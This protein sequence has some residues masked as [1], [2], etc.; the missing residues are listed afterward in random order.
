MKNI[1][2][3]DDNINELILQKSFDK[4]TAEEREKAI[5]YVGG[6]EEYNSLRNTLL[7]ITTSFSI[8]EE[9]VFDTDLKSDLLKQ[10]EQ[11]FGANNS[12][13]KIVPFYQKPFFQLA[14][15]ASVALMIFF[16]FPFFNNSTEKQGQ[17]AMNENTKESTA[18]PGT[19]N[20]KVIPDLSVSHD[21]NIPAAEKSESSKTDNSTLKNGLGQ[22]IAKEEEPAKIP[23]MTNP[24]N[25][26][27]AGDEII[28]SDDSKAESKDLALDNKPKPIV[29]ES[30]FLY[31]RVN[32][33]RKEKES[34]KSKKKA[35]DESMREEEVANNTVTKVD[36][37]K[38]LESAAGTSV[39]Q[40]NAPS[41]NKVMAA[42]TV[43][44]FVEENK[45][46]MLD[47]LFTTF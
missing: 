27:K 8:E 4:L 39:N 37:D 2:E 7:A 23:G 41:P 10:F 9:V 12:R 43:S 45:T 30:E 29:N 35:N 33:E 34:K 13:V 6:E 14:V 28:L 16:A 21:T 5:A 22:E 20:D 11:K 17:L 36:A 18:I 40:Y 32:R 44:A 42:T 15:A 31:E 47:L 46:E 3:I 25:T 38:M 1:N 19:V 24:V 26:G